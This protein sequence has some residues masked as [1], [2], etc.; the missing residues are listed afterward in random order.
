MSDNLYEE[1]QLKLSEMLLE[2]GVKQERI[3][4]YRTFLRSCL[5]IG[6]KIGESQ[7]LNEINNILLGVQQDQIDG[8][9]LKTTMDLIEKETK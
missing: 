1:M 4:N 8:L 7:M 3:E 9:F 6:R 5:A 2:D